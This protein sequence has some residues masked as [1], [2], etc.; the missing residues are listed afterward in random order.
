VATPPLTPR[1]LFL[2]AQGTGKITAGLEFT[3][4]AGEH[5]R[6]VPFAPL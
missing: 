2:F 1:A 4:A 6:R 5:A 3:L